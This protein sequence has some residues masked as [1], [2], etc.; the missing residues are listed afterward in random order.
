MGT[1]VNFLLPTA[2]G[3]AYPLQ[4]KHLC[5]RSILFLVAGY[6]FRSLLQRGLGIILNWVNQL[7]DDF[8]EDH[9][10]SEQRIYIFLEGL[11]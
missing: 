7:H 2:V 8:P 11:L 10:P 5:V 6:C 4:H 9:I 3:N 1:G